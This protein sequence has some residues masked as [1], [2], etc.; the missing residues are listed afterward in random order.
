[1]GL[2]EVV[3]GGYWSPARKLFLKDCRSIRKIVIDMK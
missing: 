3:K 1:M 2:F